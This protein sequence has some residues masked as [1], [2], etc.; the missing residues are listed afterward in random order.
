MVSS[1]GFNCTLSCKYSYIY[2]KPSTLFL[3]EYLISLVSKTL[4]PHQ[5][6]NTSFCFLKR[7]MASLWFT[8]L[9]RNLLVCDEKQDYRPT[10]LHLRAS[11]APHCEF[12]FILPSWSPDALD[13]FLHLRASLWTGSCAQKSLP[14]LSTWISAIFLAAFLLGR[15]H[16]PPTQGRWDSLPEGFSRTSLPPHSFVIHPSIHYLLTVHLRASILD[17]DGS[18][19]GISGQW[20]SSLCLGPFIATGTHVMVKWWTDKDMFQTTLLN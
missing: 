4:L 9:C 19:W 20:P 11:P 6:R 18:A 15:P 17:I 12:S 16:S 10:H 14:T 7:V 1:L 3:T 13:S 5:G 2:H 8:L